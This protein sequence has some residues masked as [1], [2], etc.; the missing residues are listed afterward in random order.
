[1]SE[2]TT[3]LLDIH[4]MSCAGCVRSVERALASVQGVT[5]ASVN[6]ASQSAA[7]SGDVSVEHLIDA[8]QSAGYDADQHVMVPLADQEQQMR[9]DL[10]EAFLKSAMLLIAASILMADMWV[11]F[12]PSTHSTPAWL[13]ISI[14]TLALMGFAGGQFYRNALIAARHGSATMDTLIALGT[15][16][17]YLY[18]VMVVFVPEVLP[19]GSRHQFFEAALYVIGF[20]SLGRAIELYSRSDTSL[21]IEKLYNLTPRQ[22]TIIENGIEQVVSSASLVKG[23]QV[24]VNPGD[25][26]PVD[27]R[28]VTGRTSV[29][30]SLMTGESIPV[31]KGEEDWVSAGT[32]NLDGSMIVEVMQAGEETRL[33][34]ISRLVAE[35]Q[36]SK[37]E[38]ARLVDQIAAIFVPLVCLVA[39]SAAFYWW[40]FGPAP[41]LSYAFVT[42]V[43]V[44]IVAC[45]CALGLAIPMSI[46]VGLGRGAASGILI[47]NSE[48][49][50]VANRMNV[51]VLDK[52]G[53]LTHGKPHVVA[54][55]GLR[56]E[57]LSFVMA[58]E[59]RATHPIADAIVAHCESL[60]VTPAEITDVR[61]IAGGGVSGELDGR[62][63]LVGSLQFLEDQSVT[64]LIEV[65]EEGTIIGV[66]LDGGFRGYFALT[67]TL[68]QE[69]AEVIKHLKSCGIRSVMATGDRIQVAQWAADQVGIEEVHGELSPE[70]KLELVQRLQFN[71]FT[72]GMIG[73][74]IND[75]I[76]LSAAD[77]SIAM[78]I[79][80]DI[81]QESADITLRE[82]SLYGLLDTLNLSRRVMNNIYQ[83]LVAAFAYNLLLIPIAAGVL[84]PTLLSPALAGLA[85]ALSSVSV[86]ANAT[87]LRFTWARPNLAAS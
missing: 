48:I 66:S 57:H 65:K 87:R 76:A 42:A 39:I 56:P 32:Q 50:Q 49:L 72:V 63:M 60:A 27:G 74:G 58:L 78:G 23:Q 17:A 28:V 80:A 67:D 20:V 47:R 26:I 12:L 79:G 44:L 21:A 4:G 45:P 24:R 83:N 68:R 14:V 53:T 18:S 2:N 6:F 25:A 30:E 77:V 3:T 41:Q 46:M 19:E 1:M 36:N 71:G 64:G 73:D 40:T 29:D 13:V 37:P 70:G 43:S 52:T 10:I 33:A 7:V 38:V 81:A 9:A 85:M 75:A 59:Q 16:M 22:V 35:A 61:Q 69:A 15:G 5:S 55:H 54:A 34:A 51:L 31:I 84:F 86:V 11:G 82:S 62:R 8:V